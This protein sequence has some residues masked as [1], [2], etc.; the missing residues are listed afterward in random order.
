MVS[1][2][3]RSCTS[4]RLG[5]GARHKFPVEANVFKGPCQLRQSGFA[6][7]P[8]LGEDR[9]SSGNRALF[10]KF[11][12]RINPTWFRR[13]FSGAIKD[14]AFR[15]LCSVIKKTWVRLVR[16]RFHKRTQNHLILIPFEYS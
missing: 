4:S 16:P 15:C 2:K 10:L 1:E 12:G 5:G 7:M 8:N 6:G 11:R 14:F 13:D 3:A 9:R